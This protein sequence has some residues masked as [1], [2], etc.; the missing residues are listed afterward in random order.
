MKGLL[1]LK[2]RRERGEGGKREGREGRERG[3]EG[4]REEGGERR[5]G[6]EGRGE[7][8]NQLKADI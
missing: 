5:E 3:E 2:G 4:K 8:F 1:Q 6:K 7:S